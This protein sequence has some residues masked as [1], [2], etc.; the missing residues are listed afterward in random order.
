MILNITLKRHAGLLKV[1]YRVSLIHYRRYFFSISEGIANNFE[2]SIDR[3]I[4]NTFLAKKKSML[5]TDIFFFI[6]LVLMVYH[7]FVAV[8]RLFILGGKIFTPL[9]TRL[10]KKH[11]E[12]VMLFHASKW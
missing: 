9:L 12:I 4:A 3:G 10:S 8:E 5:F 11:F 1:K 7:K 2:K 6:I